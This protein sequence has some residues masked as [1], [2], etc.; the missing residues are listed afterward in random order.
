ML[1]CL[2]ASA[3][4]SASAFTRS[5]VVLPVIWLQGSRNCQPRCR[6]AACHRLLSPPSST[7][8]GTLAVS[9]AHETAASTTANSGLEAPQTRANALCQLLDIFGL[10]KAGNR[11]HMTI[12]FL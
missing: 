7:S 4:F 11:E 12:V 6:H 9:A 5:S 10:L 3:T 8:R 2:P 1:N